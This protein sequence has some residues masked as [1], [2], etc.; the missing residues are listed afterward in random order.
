[1]DDIVIKQINSNLAKYL[2][3]GVSSESPLFLLQNIKE[4]MILSKGDAVLF[5]QLLQTGDADN[6]FLTLTFDGYNFDL[7]TAKHINGTIIERNIKLIIADYLR[8]NT[9]LLKYSILLS[10]QKDLILSGGII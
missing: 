9:L 8:Q 10:K 7:S 5:D 1:M 2:V 3:F 4:Q 6:R